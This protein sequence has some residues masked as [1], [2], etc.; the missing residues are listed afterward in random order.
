MRAALSVPL[1]DATLVK[2]AATG[3]LLLACTCAVLA[4]ALFW[5]LPSAVVAG[6][7]A[8]LAFRFTPTVTAIWLLITA[9]SFEMTAVDVFGPQSFQPTIALIKAAGIGLAVVAVLRWGPRLDLFNPALAWIA[10]FVGGLTHGLWPGLTAA[11]S[12]RSLVGSVAPFVFG[13]CRLSPAWA[14]HLIC[15]ARWSPM[16]SVVGGAA[17]DVAG[18][19]PMFI[20][21]GGLRLAG[22]GHPAFLA[23]VCQTAIYACLIELYRNG[24]RQDLGLLG[25][26]LLLL[27]LTGA[28][29]PL[30]YALAVVGLTLAL[31]RS[32]VFPLRQR[33]LLLAGGATA[34]PLML[35]LMFL[36]PS[37]DFSGVR[38]LNVL[39][40]DAGNLSGRQLLWPYFIR[41][42]DQSPW[43]G[44]GVGAGNFVIPLNDPVAKLLQTEAAHNEY[45]R[46]AV[47]G[48]QLGRAALV[49][50]MVLWVRQHTAR[51]RRSDRAIMRLVFVAF[52][53][54]AY[55]DNLLI[56]TPACVLFA[57]ATAVFARGRFE[58]EARL[59]AP[60]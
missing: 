52:A 60:S 53:A 17:F 33:M 9:C 43:L 23:G 41:A 22:L 37:T 18:L 24:R 15:T 13:F 32:P 36:L 5:L 48:G 8:F 34:A 19:H 21:S 44:W 3:L 35:G 58:E 42:A 12:L 49:L 29:A 20:N 10:M 38:V 57:F 40:T 39:E 14:R 7:I 59:R 51:L 11:E 27:V 56:S 6:A 1:Q 54:H 26:N 2:L 47:E 4:P 31:V 25:L 28:R 45:L 46:V 16:L 50:L 30:A 55:T